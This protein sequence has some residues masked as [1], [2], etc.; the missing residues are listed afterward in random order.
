MAPNSVIYGIRISSLE[1]P[2]SGRF[3]IPVSTLDILKHTPYS[4]ALAR[5]GKSNLCRFFLLNQEE[6]RREDMMVLV[7]SNVV[8]A[9]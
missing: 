8:L 5:E 6:K 9:A 1:G 4:T 2:A 7:R 3:M